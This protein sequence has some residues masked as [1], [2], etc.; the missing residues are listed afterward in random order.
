MKNL[1]S[2][3]IER[4]KSPVSIAAIVAQVVT[5]LIM[6]K[7]IDLQMGDQINQIAAAFLQLGV[8]LGV[9]NNPSDKD[10]F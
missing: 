7:V 9:L 6:L 5:I 3:L 8:L 1:L 2:T 10:N 4:F